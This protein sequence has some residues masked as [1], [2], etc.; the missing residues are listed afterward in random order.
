M[1][2]AIDGA[3]FP[4]NPT[5]VTNIT[6]SIANALATANPDWEIY[7]LTNGEVHAD[8][9]KMI[10]KLPN[11]TLIVE[12]LPVLQS[13]AIFWSL[14]KVNLLV[15]KI[16][17]DYFIA[18]N[19]LVSPFFFQHKIPTIVFVHDLVHRKFRD[20]MKRITKLHMDSLFKYSLRKTNVIWCNSNYTSKELSNHFARIVKRKK[21]F[22]GSALNDSFLEKVKLSHNNESY[23]ERITSK[24]KPYLLFVGTLA[25]RK[26]LIF[27]LH[28]Y[29]K[30]SESFTL[31]IVGAKG[32]GAAS[33]EIINLLK[34]PGYPKDDIVFP[35]YVTVEQLINIYK[36]A[37]LF[38]STS[39]D[40][41]LGLPQLE[42]MACGCPVISP[43][44]SAMI[45]VV[46]GAGITVRGWEE[47]DWLQAIETIKA[48][49][50]MYKQKGFER[51]AAYSWTE[52]INRF[53]QDV[54]EDQEAIK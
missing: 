4:R 54:L 46:E 11:L 17:P 19:F 14:F 23:I 16:K 35:G 1:K 33:D 5:G 38:I 2:I 45:E 27:L 52:V 7:L 20:T 28:L 8:V 32:W 42:A 37:F 34:E 44:N 41:G 9:Q 49:R 31:V 43:H 12:P 26:N 30:L 50:E 40:E 51:V 39:L 15:K 10:H 24:R 48:N 53:K 13:Y 29:K 21:V 18:P 25:P 36:N 3:G 47:A 6:I 22:T